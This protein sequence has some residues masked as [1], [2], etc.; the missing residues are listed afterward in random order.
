MTEIYPYYEIKN[1]VNQFCLSKE[2][3]MESQG[4]T[5][6]SRPC[7]KTD[8]K[9]DTSVREI[10]DRYFYLTTNG[11]K[12]INKDYLFVTKLNNSKTMRVI[13]KTLNKYGFIVNKD[14]LILNVKENATQLLVDESFFGND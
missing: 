14:G 11:K 4:W 9:Y 6:E 8:K 1:F 3:L 13:N 7:E 5:I 12:I 2:E 10:D